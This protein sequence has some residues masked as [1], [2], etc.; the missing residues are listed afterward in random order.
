MDVGGRHYGILQVG[1]TVQR[2]N[3]QRGS[4]FRKGWFVVHWIGFAHYDKYLSSSLPPMSLLIL[5]FNVRSSS[6][7]FVYVV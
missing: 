6:L 5:S 3:S 1:K 7:P 4:I 2:N